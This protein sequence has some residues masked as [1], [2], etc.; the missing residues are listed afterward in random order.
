MQ[1]SFAKVYS[2]QSILCHF[3]SSF[4]A[5]GEML[6]HLDHEGSILSN[7]SALSLNSLG[8]GNDTGSPLHCV[9]PLVPCCDTNRSGN[10][11][12]GDDPLGV[13][14][15]STELF[16]SWGDDQSVR[17][18]RG[19]GGASIEGGL[20]RCEVPDADTVTQTLYVGVYGSDDEGQ[21]TTDPL[22]G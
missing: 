4:C 2:L 5:A 8:D 9:T 12:R 17:L 6:V 7:N 22:V 21:F 13:F 19:A 1:E 11:F 10:W 14:E 16:Q 15:N 20:Y 18:N 3:D